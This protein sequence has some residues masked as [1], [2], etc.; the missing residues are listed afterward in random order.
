MG[1]RLDSERKLE[2]FCSWASQEMS[3]TGEKRMPGIVI[4]SVHVIH[5]SQNRVWGIFLL[6]A[7]Q[8]LCPCSCLGF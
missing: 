7:V 4:G 3:T 6:W 1:C 2:R 5:F 8:W